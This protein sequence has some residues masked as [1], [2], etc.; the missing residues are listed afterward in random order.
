MAR[1]PDPRASCLPLCTLGRNIGRSKLNHS[2]HQS[3][4]PAP[5]C[6]TPPNTRV[7]QAVLRLTP[8][9][10]PRVTT[11]LQ[12]P[13]AWRARPEDPRILPRLKEQ[14]VATQEAGWGSQVSREMT[15]PGVC[16]TLLP[17]WMVVSLASCHR[18]RVVAPSDGKI[19]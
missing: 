9:S 8:S 2:P 16:R 5:R 3:S 6:Q 1:E 12:A 11:R 10:Y 14:K 13:R 4:G 18:H 19:S 17:Q 15:R 7:A